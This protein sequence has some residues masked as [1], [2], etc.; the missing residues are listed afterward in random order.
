MPRSKKR[1]RAKSVAG[2]STCRHF[3]RTHVRGGLCGAR[4]V[5]AFVID[6]PRNCKDW[7]PKV[8]RA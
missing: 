3:R 8:D 5:G 7:S 4:V 2:C 1:N 6:G